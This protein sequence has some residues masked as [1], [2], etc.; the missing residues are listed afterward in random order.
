MKNTQLIIGVSL[1]AVI[2]A[3]GY[4]YLHQASSDSSSPAETPRET[5]T[6]EMHGM[7]NMEVLTERD[8]I[9]EM[10]PH[11]EEA[12][13]TSK[14]MLARSQNAE[15]RKLTEAIITAQ[16]KEIADMK[17]WYETWYGE[18][19]TATGTYEA[20]MP[21][22]ATLSDSELDRAYL[23]GMIEHHMM[24]LMMAQQVAQAIE[25]PEIATLAQSIAQTQSAEIISMR[26]LLKQI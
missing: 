4:A 25:H 19:Y 16:E 1:L 14:I 23:Q 8:F 12:V 22:L 20:M 7:H 2:T 18:P 15:V 21:D 26:I 17:S 5:F 11:H 24:A 6:S 9:E 13:E 3:G 10:I